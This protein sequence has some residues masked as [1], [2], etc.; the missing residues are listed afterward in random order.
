M[1]Q[2]VHC[3]DKNIPMYLAEWGF[4]GLFSCH[5]GSK[6]GVCILFNNNFN[7]QIHKSFCDPEGQFILCDLKIGQF[8][9]ILGNI[10]APNDDNPGFFK[11]LFEQLQTLKCEEMMRNDNLVLAINKD[12]KG[13][14]AK[15]HQK[16]VKV[17]EH[18]ANELDLVDVWR[19][20]NQEKPRYTW[21]RRNPGVHCWLDFFLASQT[22]SNI[23]NAG[24]VSGYKTDH[25]M[26]TLTILLHTN[27]RGRGVWKLNTS[28]LTK[29]DYVNQINEQ[30]Q[31]VKSVKQE[32][33]GEN[34]VNSALLWEIVKL[35]V[36]EKS[37]SYGVGKKRAMSREKEETEQSISQ[38]EK[39]KQI[40][41]QHSKAKREN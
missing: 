34:S 1:L 7:L 14:L 15:T 41:K 33:Q 4:Q 35:K 13:G 20:Q 29:S 2:E 22:L 11:L 38:L 17:I 12:K 6:A 19:A 25:S 18:F 31:S 24:I 27:T 5:S 32:Y 8:C 16:S 40:F 39:E 21:R 23:T 36:G 28:F 10:Y 30:I 3:I 9:I 37:I 26:I